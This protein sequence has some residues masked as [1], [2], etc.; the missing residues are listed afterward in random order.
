[1][2]R[3]YHVPPVEVHALRVRLEKSP[4]LDA[5]H[6]RFG[7][8][9]ERSLDVL[10]E[11]ITRAMDMLGSDY[12]NRMGALTERMTQL[13]TAIHLVY[14]KVLEG[15]GQP[16]D[17]AALRAWFDELHRT[18]REV[19]AP[20][21]WIERTAAG[22]APPTE[23]PP[24]PELT[25]PGGR[26][27]VAEKPTSAP[28]ENQLRPGGGRWHEESHPRSD[29][30]LRMD[31][32]GLYWAWP[33]LKEGVVQH[34]PDLGY[35]VWLDPSGAVVEEVVT[36]GPSMT[37]L[38]K[39]TAGEDVMFTSGELGGVYGRHRMERAHGAMSPG[40]GGADSPHGIAAAHPFI[41]QTLENHG[42][43]AWVRDLKNNAPPGVDY[44]WRTETSSSRQLLTERRYTVSVVVEGR[45]HDMVTLEVR[46][47]DPEAG[48]AG[49]QA[50]VVRVDAGLVQRYGFPTKT[51]PRRTTAAAAP[52]TVGP[53]ESLSR[54]LGRTQRTGPDPVH[55]AVAAV[56]ERVSEL[57][58]AMQ[59]TLTRALAGPDDPRARRDTT[60]PAA[61]AAL[62]RWSALTELQS[63]LEEVQSELEHG[64]VVD[65]ERLGRLESTLRTVTDGGAGRWARGADPAAVRALARA[66]DDVLREP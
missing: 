28:R 66:L 20:R 60:S 9:R 22:S 61:R 6:E 34:F 38:R 29:I 12:I 27:G 13:R 26:E 3:S 42:I 56:G 10:T 49:I 65:P 19:A 48:V 18:S 58:R 31:V 40:A 7:V 46:V 57:S 47:P 63:R 25:L 15:T 52:V 54:A 23:L 2:S 51:A 53:S 55:P 14:A 35:R 8:E 1:M 39:L 5:L 16:V 32:D 45:L 44:V 36:G 64:A 37:S 59:D 50:D 41:N 17:T 4:L 24:P 33:P 62:D 43:E 11:S 21:D 30:R